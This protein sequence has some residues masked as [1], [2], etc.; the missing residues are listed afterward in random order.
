MIRPARGQVLVKEA[1]IEYTTE[2]GIVVGV[3][4]R[5]LPDVMKGTVVAVGP[6]CVTKR[7]VVVPSELQP[8]DVVYWSCKYGVDV[9]VAGEALL[10]LREEHIEGVEANG[11]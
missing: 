6:G 10:M 8:G 5:R 11:G 7:G 2:A 3:A 9:E 4:A 1:P